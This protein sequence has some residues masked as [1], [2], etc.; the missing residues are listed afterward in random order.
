ML[1]KRHKPNACHCLIALLPY[2]LLLF[3]VSG[4]GGEGSLVVAVGIS[5]MWQVTGDTPHAT[6]NM[7]HRKPD[8]FCKSASVQTGWEIQCLPYAGLF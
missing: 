2:R 8:F 6:R 1:K 3:I 7:W 4:L 5:D